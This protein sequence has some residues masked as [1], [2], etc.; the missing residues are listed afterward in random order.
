[1]V[2]VIDTSTVVIDGIPLR[3]LSLVTLNQDSTVSGIGGGVIT[4]RI[5]YEAGNWNLGFDCGTDGPIDLFRCYSDV[6]IT[7]VD[8]N[9]HWDCASLEGVREHD[10]VTG[11][12][13]FPNPGTDQFTV[14]LP[15]GKYTI[16]LF[17][18]T[19]LSV[20]REQLIGDRANVNTI[21]LVPGLFTYRLST[22]DGA[23]LAQG[24]WVKE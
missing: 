19:G 7:Y 5:G 14:Q 22:S 11:S 13:I 15:T 12:W 2:Q 3:R 18:A 23:L 10:Q 21:A 24:R 6:D 17:N 4:E 20:L 16:E 1:M 9:W 8:P